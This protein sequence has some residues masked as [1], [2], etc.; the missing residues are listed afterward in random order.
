[1]N[2]SRQRQSIGGAGKRA[3]SSLVRLS[4]ARTTIPWFLVLECTLIFLTIGRPLFLGFLVAVTSVP[5]FL[6]RQSDSGRLAAQNGKKNCNLKKHI[7]KYFLGITYTFPP[8]QK[9]LVITIYLVRA[10]SKA[11]NMKIIGFTMLIF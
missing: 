3:Q 2:I 8:I 11:I 4:N 1:M 5:Y 9:A 10:L 6:S 7:S